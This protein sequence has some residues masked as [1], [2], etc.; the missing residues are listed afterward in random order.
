MEDLFDPILVK[1]LRDAKAALARHG[2]VILRTIQSELEPAIL[3]KVR[4]SMASSQGRLNRMSD[5]DLDEFMGEVRKAATKAA[6]ELATL[7]THLLT[8]LGSE[9][10]VDLVKELDG[11]NQLFR[12]E[13]IAKVADPVSV[14]LV[15]KGFDR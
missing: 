7:H 6:T 2:I 10:V 9:Y 12:W 13:R 4:D 15:S 5:E 1:N 8:K 14:L 11:I 3:V